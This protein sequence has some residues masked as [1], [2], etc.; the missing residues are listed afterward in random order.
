M[1]VGWQPW[2]PFCLPPV[3]DPHTVTE[4]KE[5]VR[6]VAWIQCRIQTWSLFSMNIR[7]S[8]TTLS[9]EKTL[10]EDV[11]FRSSPLILA[12]VK[13]LSLPN[14]VFW[15]SPTDVSRQVVNYLL[16]RNLFSIITFH[17]RVNIF[18]VMLCS[19]DALPLSYPDT[20]L[21]THRFILSKL[22][23]FEPPHNGS[24]ESKTHSEVSYSFVIP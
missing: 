12:A 17:V 13:S 21:V 7:E 6:T 2:S 22:S 16:W 19:S 5:A 4:L 1:A 14:L 15:V 24:L 10:R 8:H 18:N 3:S 23:G 9:K 11:C 20:R